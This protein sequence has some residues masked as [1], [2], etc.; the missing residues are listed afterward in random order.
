MPT[1]LLLLLLPTTTSIR[2][3]RLKIQTISREVNDSYIRT[4]S[5]IFIKNE[6]DSALFSSHM[7]IHL[8][9]VDP[10]FYS[11]FPEGSKELNQVKQ[12]LIDL[13]KF[14]EFDHL[15]RDD[16]KLDSNYQK[17]LE[18]IVKEFKTCDKKYKPFYFNQL[19]R[20][21]LNGIERPFLI[22]T[23]HDY[24]LTETIEFLHFFDGKNSD[25]R[26]MRTWAQKVNLEFRSKENKLDFINTI[27]NNCINCIA[28][29]R[30][31]LD[32]FIEYLSKEKIKIE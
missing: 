3:L 27:N 30:I 4:D 1:I 29:E 13:N 31:F 10:S 14:K 6:K 12:E 18:P 28:H 15:K 7:P 17:Y 26:I 2:F 11:Y 19:S 23:C 8:N 22:K 16:L 24:I 9:H 20:I 5:C 25:K 32:S 21:I